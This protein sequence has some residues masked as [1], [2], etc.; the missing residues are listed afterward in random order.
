VGS[1]AGASAWVIPS[2]WWTSEPQIEATSTRTSSAPGSSSS[3]R[4]TGSSRISI[5]LP[6]S[7]TTAARAVLGRRMASV[8]R[9]HGLAWITPG[10]EILRDLRD[11]LPR[12]LH[13]DVRRELAG[14]DEVREPS[15][16]EARRLL[17]QLDEQIEAVERRAPA[18][19][20]VARVE[21]DLAGGGHAEGH[22]RAAARERAQRRAQ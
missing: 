17:A 15:Q 12:P 6:Y 9:E 2:H 3:S 10:Y 18:D 16:P 14:G 11:L 7:A 13:A 19:E 20:E 22:A 8:H 21:G 4:G 5:G 1:C